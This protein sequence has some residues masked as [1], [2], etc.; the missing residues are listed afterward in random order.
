MAARC[1]LSRLHRL[2]REAEESSPSYPLR[3]PSTAVPGFL[4]KASCGSGLALCQAC[5]EML[6]VGGSWWVFLASLLSSLPLGARPAA[7]PLSG[8]VL[9]VELQREEADR[10][11]KAMRGRLSPLRA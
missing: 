11:V 3:A 4:P 7:A 1:G 8:Q 10:L 9:C 6:Q 2:L 5:V